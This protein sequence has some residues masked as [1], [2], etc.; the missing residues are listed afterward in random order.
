M[1][2]FQIQGGKRICW[3]YLILFYFVFLS[4]KFILTLQSLTNK[5]V[6]S[7]SV[8]ISTPVQHRRINVAIPYVQFSLP[9]QNTLA[10]IAGYLCRKILSGHDLLSSC[11]VC[12]KALLRSDAELDDP[13]LLFIHNKAYDTSKSDFGSLMVPSDE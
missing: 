6:T 8:Q 2:W 9:R 10:N 11:L 3:G 12:R 1:V 7:Q 5:T 13:A 4:D